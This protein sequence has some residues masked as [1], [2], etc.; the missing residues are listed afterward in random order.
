MD[1]FRQSV[2]DTNSIK[3]LSNR[4]KGT[5]ISYFDFSTLYTTIPHDKLMKVLFEIVDFCFK[6]S[7]IFTA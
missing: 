7:E 2:S 4:G 1:N 3:S 6:G 5:S